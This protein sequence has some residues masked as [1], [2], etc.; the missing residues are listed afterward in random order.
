[1]KETRTKK[2]MLR[3]VMRI[4]RVFPQ[5]QMKMEMKHLRYGAGIPLL[6]FMPWNRQKRFIRKTIQILNWIFRKIFIM[7]LRQS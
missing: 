1:M 2:K 5:K 7:I 4:R 6:I 3:T